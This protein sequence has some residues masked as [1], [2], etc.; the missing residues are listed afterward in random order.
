MKLNL[1]RFRCSHCGVDILVHEGT[2]KTM[3]ICSCGRWMGFHDKEMIDV[4]AHGKSAGDMAL[5]GEI[6]K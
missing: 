4:K 6:K 5:K 1:L 2:D 3:I